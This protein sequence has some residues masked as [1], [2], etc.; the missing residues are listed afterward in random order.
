MS[1]RL[2][3]G[4]KSEIENMCVVFWNLTA[5]DTI[6]SYFNPESNQSSTQF[7]TSGKLV[8]VYQSWDS[9]GGR[10]KFMSNCSFSPQNKFSLVN[11]WVVY[12][13]ISH[14][15]VFAIIAQKT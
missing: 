6:N 8:L 10:Q 4:A 9:Y 15:R 13:Q 1:Q 7:A 2:K 14:C 11:I 3:F 5:G 12:S